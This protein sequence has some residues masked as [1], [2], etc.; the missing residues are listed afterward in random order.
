MHDAK[1]GGLL[2]SLRQVTATAL[3]MVQIRLELLG[4]ELEFEKR[5]L[6]DG[7][8]IAAAA[9]VFFGVGLLSLCGFIIVLFW[10]DH[11]LLALASMTVICLGMGLVLIVQSRKRLKT[12][13]GI[14]Y[15]SAAELASD[16]AQVQAVDRRE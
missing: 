14:F 6:F 7:I 10:E 13:M 4:T 8:L 16:R 11:R 5:R 2:A 15:A 1:S 9:M 12:P 3:E